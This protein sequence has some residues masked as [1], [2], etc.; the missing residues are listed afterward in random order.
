MKN[1]LIEVNGMFEQVS[2]EKEEL[3]ESHNKEIDEITETG[4][5]EI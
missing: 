5:N 1:E 2:K 4:I 3:E